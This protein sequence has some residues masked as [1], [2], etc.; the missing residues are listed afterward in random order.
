MT[1]FSTENC[2]FRVTERDPLQWR[3]QKAAGVL[4]GRG[5]R[6]GA[7]EELRE[8]LQRLYKEEKE[9]RRL[10][11]RLERAETIIAVQKNSRRCCR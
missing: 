5:K 10:R 8:A 2:R 11:Q 7:S 3:R 9:N 4:V 1:H 6:G